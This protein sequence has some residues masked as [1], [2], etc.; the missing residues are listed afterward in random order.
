[1]CVTRKQKNKGSKILHPTTPLV[2]I[3]Y[4]NGKVCELETIIAFF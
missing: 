4:E 1:M 2:V 3:C